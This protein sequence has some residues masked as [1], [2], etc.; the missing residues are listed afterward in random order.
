MKV[1]NMLKIKEEYDY[2]SLSRKLDIQLDKLMAES[3]RQQKAFMDRVEMINKEA[4]NR[5]IDAEMKYA[6]ALEVSS[7][8][9]ISNVSISSFFSH[10]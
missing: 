3:E 7:V 6:E 5:M 10:W 9:Y 8:D 2:K 4:Q 1:Q